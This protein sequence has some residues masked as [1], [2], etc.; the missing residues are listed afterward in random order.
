MYKG[1]DILKIIQNDANSH[2]DMIAYMETFNDNAFTPYVGTFWYNSSSNQLFGV[3]KVES[4]LIPFNKSGLKTTPR[5]HKQIWA[6]EYNKGKQANSSST[7]FNQPDYTK[8]ARG[9]VFQRVDNTFE[10]MV[11][12]WIKNYPEAKNVILSEFELPEADTQFIIDSHWNIGSGW[13]GDK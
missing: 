8:V 13:E 3:V 4:D 10:V 6:K 2:R 11:G 7:L 5:L 12:N 1:D 9:R